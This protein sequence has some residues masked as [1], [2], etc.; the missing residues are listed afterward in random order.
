MISKKM[1][2]ISM[3]CLSLVLALSLAFGLSSF[4][5]FNKANA[6]VGKY[7]T[8]T[9]GDEVPS[10]NKTQRTTTWEL[11]KTEAVSAFA[12]EVEDCG[13][14]LSAGVTIL[15]ASNKGKINFSKAE[16]SILIPV[17]GAD[18][19]GTV[20]LRS[21]GS[22]SN[23][24]QTLSGTTI[25]GKGDSSFTTASFTSSDL[26]TKV[27]GGETKYFLKLSW[28]KGTFPL[29]AVQLVDNYTKVVKTINSVAAPTGT[30]EVA[31]DSTN[32]DITSL[33]PT[34]LVGSWTGDDSTSG[35]V[36]VPVTWNVEGSTEVAGTITATAVLGSV[37]GYEKG[38]IIAP[39]VEITV[40][41]PTQITA[42]SIPSLINV[43]YEG[44]LVGLP[45]TLSIT[46]EDGTKDENVTWYTSSFNNTLIGE[47]QTILGTIDGNYELA[48]GVVVEQKVLVNKLTVTSVAELDAITLINRD[49]LNRNITV[50]VTLSDSRKIN[51]PATL[52]G[53]VDNSANGL[54]H[55]VA[56]LDYSS[57]TSY[58]DTTGATTTL[59]ANVNVVFYVATEVVIFEKDVISDKAATTNLF[60]G[61]TAGYTVDV[62]AGATMTYSGTF[63]T[64][65]DRAYDTDS[66]KSFGI[67]YTK[68]ATLFS[69]TIPTGFK[70]TVNVAWSNN[71]ASLTRYTAFSTD[72]AYSPTTE[73]PVVP[74][75]TQCPVEYSYELPTSTEKTT[76]YLVHNEDTLGIHYMS[77]LVE[78]GELVVTP[79]KEGYTFIGEYEGVNAFARLSYL[80]IS[81]RKTG[82]AAVRFGFVLEVVDADD[83]ALNDLTLSARGVFNV[84][85]L[86]K[87][88]PTSANVNF[89]TLNIAYNE[90]AGGYLTNLAITD[91][92]SAKAQNALNVDLTI[93]I[94]GATI[95]AESTATSVDTIVSKAQVAYDAGYLTN[96]QASLYGVTLNSAE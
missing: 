79:T 50:E 49:E 17:Y 14:Y 20:G 76:Y 57:F 3:V 53:D 21:H 70:A 16:H 15:V 38:S 33:L 2:N 25:Q 84:E 12:A 23:F 59:N 6:D 41:D 81:F 89:A 61:T 69:I 7:F 87:E 78:E 72:S 47:E 44:Q 43:A 28:Q 29:R 19:T 39:T 94:N 54:Y 22:G 34:T 65:T 13:V 90:T 74:F 71:N 86:S 46:T 73:N 77:V 5:N 51:V 31:L 27:V 36:D 88:V 66:H 30:Y 63:T 91:I 60:A 67:K 18:S 75:G 68:G 8:S 83:N 93:T 52:S 58:V 1:R 95:T 64:A 26:V 37:S 82:T 80:G 4:S 56:T 85:N 42:V 35:E 45:T 92:D 24:L 10:G 96:E 48:T 9:V 55:V 32:E 62:G 40:K 11:T